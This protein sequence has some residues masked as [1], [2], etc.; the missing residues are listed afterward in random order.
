MSSNIVATSTDLQIGKGLKHYA[1]KFVIATRHFD[2][3]NVDVTW[4]GD[5]SN[6]GMDI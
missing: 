6:E 5:E 3:L 4:R 2:S 1:I